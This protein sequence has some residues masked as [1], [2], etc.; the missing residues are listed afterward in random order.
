MRRVVGRHRVPAA[1]CLCAALASSSC[2][3]EA[4]PEPRSLRVVG[5]DTMLR[6]A[7]LWADAFMRREPGFRVDV[8]GGGSATGIEALIRGECEIAAASRPLLPNEVRRLEAARGR[9][10]VSLRVAR[11]AVAVYLHPD[12]P[13]RDLTLLQVKGLFNG[14]IGSWHKV[15]GLEEPVQVLVRPPSSGTYRL[16]RE[17]ALDDE[18]YSAR[19]RTLPTTAAIVGAVR[20]DRTAIGYGGLGWGSDVRLSAIDGVLPVPESVRSGDYPLARYLYLHTAAPPRGPIARFTEFALGAEGQALVAD[21]GF[22]PL[23]D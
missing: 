12:N 22:V 13:V 18:V 11:D 21:A 3:V 10:G 16:F 6:L 5:S 1:A 8:S 19:A 9:L 15:G 7:T 20:S 4:P 2:R 17:L 14:R 23:F